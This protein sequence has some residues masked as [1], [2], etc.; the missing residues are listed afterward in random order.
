MLCS[1]E[2]GISFQKI[3]QYSESSF[4]KQG[5]KS[6]KFRDSTY[7]SA[8]F[9]TICLDY[10]EDNILPCDALVAQNFSRWCFFISNDII[11]SEFG[12]FHF[13]RKFWNPPFVKNGKNIKITFFLWA[14]LTSNSSSYISLFSSWK[15]YLNRVNK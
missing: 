12:N 15:F 11:F 6:Q 10:P 5:Q 9:Q 1:Q 8:K 7:L 3:F 14:S 4:I 13:L 2:I